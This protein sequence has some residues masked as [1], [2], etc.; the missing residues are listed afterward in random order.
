MDFYI[1]KYQCK[2][3]E[4]LTP[5]F[6]C[7]TDGVHRLERQEEQEEVE[8]E[9]ARKEAAEETAD[10]AWFKG[11]ELDL[12]C[13]ALRVHQEAFLPTE[14]HEM[15][16]TLAALSAVISQQYRAIRAPFSQVLANESESMLQGYFPV[17]G[18]TITCVV[19]TAA[20]KTVV[21][22]D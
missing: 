4:A 1:T 22:F 5:L 8:A 7:M 15:D 11:Q 19:D 18:K 17:E 12:L 13:F 14:T 21:D 20:E 16:N 6:K 9:R 3:M 2:A 10:D